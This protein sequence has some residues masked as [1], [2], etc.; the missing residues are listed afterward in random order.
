MLEN[1]LDKYFTSLEKITGKQEQAYS[2][3]DV[4]LRTLG[5]KN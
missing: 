3:L 1:F 4:Y 5:Y 2:A